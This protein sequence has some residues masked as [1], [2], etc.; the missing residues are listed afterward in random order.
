MNRDPSFLF[1]CLSDIKHKIAWREVTFTS[2]RS[3]ITDHPFLPISHL[4]RNP[5]F[6]VLGQVGP[7]GPPPPYYNTPVSPS[8]TPR[9]IQS[10]FPL[11]TA[12]RT[13]VRSRRFAGSPPTEVT[14]IVTISHPVPRQ[15]PHQQIPVSTVVSDT[16]SNA[17]LC[18]GARKHSADAGVIAVQP[19]RKRKVSGE[20]RPP[21]TCLFTL[22]SSRTPRHS[23][24]KGR[25]TPP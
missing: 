11:P 21:N 15:N 20:L 23:K 16:R 22:H 3:P 10:A 12:S 24:R 2:H 8:P 13:S 6:P 9:L 5:C 19:R 14:A 17:D 18:P 1:V 7:C 4:P 25:R